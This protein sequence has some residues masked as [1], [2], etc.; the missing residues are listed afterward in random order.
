[1]EE[2]IIRCVRGTQSTGV[3]WHTP[4]PHST[5][6]PTSTSTQA[7]SK[8]K[9]NHAGE[10]GR[11]EARRG[12]G[13]DQAVGGARAHPPPPGLWAAGHGP[14][15]QGRP[16]RGGG[17]RGGAGAAGALFGAG[18]ELA[19][20]L[21][22]DGPDGAARLCRGQGTG[23]AHHRRQGR[24]AGRGAAAAGAGAGAEEA[25]DGAGVPAAQ[26]VCECIFWLGFD[27]RARLFAPFRIQ[28]TTAQHHA[29]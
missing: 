23:P 8:P 25:N 29:Q 1:M 28:H 4:T 10:E 19:G 7:P 6:H 3:T 18:D 9:P 14:A 13:R 15:A 26:G 21:L 27:G 22:G 16:W 5:P 20:R 17:R 11:R 2:N 12:Q 24:H